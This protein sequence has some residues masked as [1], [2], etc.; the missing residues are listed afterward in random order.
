[1][2]APAAPAHNRTSSVAPA[3]RGEALLE[4]SA[5]TRVSVIVSVWLLL[6]GGV[7]D[8]VLSASERARIWVLLLHFIVSVLTAAAVWVELAREAPPARRWPPARYRR[9]YD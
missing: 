3:G 2:S 8:A 1:L 5:M 4:V 9:A 7:G 6:T